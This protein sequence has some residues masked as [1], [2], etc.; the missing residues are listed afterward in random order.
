MN[1]GGTLSG[2]A[3]FMEYEKEHE[4]RSSTPDSSLYQNPLVNYNK[5][6]LQ[7]KYH[8]DAIHVCLLKGCLR[9]G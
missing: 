2:R 3:V 1:D 6:S 5:K 7:E 9:W 4:I 8:F